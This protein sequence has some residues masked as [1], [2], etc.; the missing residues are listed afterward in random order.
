MNHLVT[1]AYPDFVRPVLQRRVATELRVPA[2]FV[3]RV[4]NSV[5][6]RVAQRRCLFLG[7]S[8]GARIDVFRRSNNPELSHEQI[9]PTYD[10][11]PDRV[12]EALGKL[13]A[14]LTS[15]L[16]STPPEE[17]CKFGTIVLLDDFSASGV[18]YLRKNAAGQVE[19]KL[20]KFRKRIADPKE[21]SS[22]LADL[23][24]SEVIVLLYMATEQARAHLEGICREIWAPSGANCSVQVV[25]PLRA[26]LKIAAGDGNLFGTLLEKYYDPT[27]ETESSKKGGTDL[28]YG[29][30]ACGLPLVLSHNTPNNSV[31]LLWAESKKLRALFPRVDRHRK[32]A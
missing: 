13:R 20:E 7:L 11:S 10:I 17:L 16:G 26:Q 32:E 23:S 6:F 5:Q 14:D 30:A 1:M 2:R 15:L 22:A 18:S 25:H 29:F 27:I 9:L 3:K 24:R 8:D 31:Y 28:K 21:P 19:G 4:A 12:M